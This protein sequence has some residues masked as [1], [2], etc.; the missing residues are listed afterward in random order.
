MKPFEIF[1]SEAH[2][3]GNELAYVQ[4]ALLSNSITTGGEM[5]AQFEEDLMHFFDHKVRISATNSG[6]SAIHLGLLLLGVQKGDEV[7]CQSFTFSASVNPV[8]YLGATPVFI[9]SESETWNICPLAL[10][11]AIQ[12]RMRKGKKPKAII[13]VD[14]YGMPFQVEAITAVASKYAI[15][16]LEDSAEALGSRYK[17][18]P[19]GTFG[20]VGILSFNGNKIISASSGGAVLVATESQ[21]SKVQFWASQSKDEAPHY[22]H[23]EVGYNYGMSTITAAIGLA[24]LKVLDQRIEARRANHFFY[25]QLFET[26]PWVTIQVEPSDDFYSNFWLTTILIDSERSNGK[27]ANDLR[28]FMQK[29][30][31]ETRPLWK[32]MHLQPV[33]GDYSYFGD[34][35][36]EDLFKR[37]LCLPS[38]SNMSDQQ[39]IKIR[40]AI[41][42]FFRA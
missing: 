21:K 30:G 5:V 3:S 11:K 24:Q 36:E 13:V 1:L 29:H 4:K 14:L 37:G 18:Q 12:E 22:Q 35:V 39:K 31:I 25:R 6:T 23:S 7:L 38:G 2:Q 42:E 40:N 32:P 33:F 26:F 8:L 15:P 27:T 17:G 16:I 20:S 19:C 10:E 28:Q 9:G 41:Q 34:K